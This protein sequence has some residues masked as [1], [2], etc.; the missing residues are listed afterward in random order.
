MPN[1][2]NDFWHCWTCQE[3]STEDIKRCVWSL[4]EF[5]FFLICGVFM[6]LFLNG[7]LKSH[8][9]PFYLGWRLSVPICTWGHNPSIEPCPEDCGQPD[10]EDLSCRR[11]FASRWQGFRW[12]CDIESGWSALY[13]NP[14][15]QVLLGRLF[16]FGSSLAQW[17]WS[18]ILN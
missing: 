5:V 15:A 2:P 10:F 1:I 4:P 6:W 8:E 7:Q 11:P 18:R 3:V 17:S 12:E 9:W 13:L 16:M 14:G